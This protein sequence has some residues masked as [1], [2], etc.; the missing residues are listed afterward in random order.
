MGANVAGR[1]SVVCACGIVE[2]EAWQSRDFK[3]LIELYG[4]IENELT[5]SENDKLVFARRHETTR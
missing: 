5:D 1:P 2:D 3:K 4:P